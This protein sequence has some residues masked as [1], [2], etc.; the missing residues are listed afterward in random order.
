MALNLTVKALSDINQTTKTNQL[1][2]EIEGIDLI[3]GTTP[4][5]RFWQIGDNAVIGQDGLYI[6]GV[7]ENEKS[8][9]YISLDGTTR[10]IT[11]QI[12]EQGG[13]SSI[14]KMD[15][16]LVDKNGEVSNAL[17]KNQLLVDPIGVKANVY[18]AFTDTSG[19]GLSGQHPRDSI[20]IFNG[21][22]DGISFGVGNVVLSV[23]HP[24]SA[25]RQ[26][27]FVNQ[28]TE[29]ASA[30]TD[31]QTSIQL[32]STDNLL[33]PDGYMQSYI[34]VEDEIIQYQGK[35]LTTL[36][37]CTRGALGT[38]AVAHDIDTETSSIYRLTDNPINM[39]LGLM[40]SGSNYSN[41]TSVLHLTKI[42][43]VTSNVNAIVFDEYDIQERLGL[44]VGD[45]VLLE[46]TV[47][48]DFA[49]GK[50]TG[51]GKSS[52]GSYVL[53]TTDLTEELNTSATFST[54]SKYD[55][56][57]DGCAMKTDQVDIAQ[58]EFILS[59]FGTSFPQLQFYLKDTIKAKEFIEKEIYYPVSMGQVSRKGRASLRYNAPPVAGENVQTL[60]NDN[61]KNAENI[62]IKR[63]ANNNLFNSVIYKYNEDT[64]TDKFLSGLI[65][66]DATSINNIKVGNKPLT[67]ESKGL[68]KGSE[69]YLDSQ[70]VRYLDRFAG[71]AESVDVEVNFKTGFSI[72]VGDSVIFNPSISLPDTKNGTR[73]F[74][75]RIMECVNKSV[76]LL[77]GDIKLSLLDTS[78][79]INGRYTTIAPAS[80]IY[81]VNGSSVSVINLSTGQFDS[82]KWVDFEGQTVLVHS[83]DWTFQLE[84]TLTSVGTNLV[85]AN[86]TGV[87]SGMILDTPQYSGN[88]K[89]KA[90][91]KLRHGYINPHRLVTGQV[92]SNSFAVSNV[93]PFFIGA[94]LSLY[95]SD[96]STFRGEFTIIGISSNIMTVDRDVVVSPNDNINLLGFV[97][98]NGQPYRYL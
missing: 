37:G 19:R 52:Y 79:A 53:V 13:S 59:T 88:A 45:W 28:K 38:T 97:S 2:V 55:I 91:Y 26:D 70:S 92:A 29:L 35:V 36:T 82:S 21:V 6:G 27:L 54:K 5:Y 89:E 58:H 30:I 86:T 68:R 7:F 41:P 65:T 63:S 64:L 96:Y 32:K 66:I 69:N 90:F 20:K 17:S 83:S 31:V 85:L 24:E 57:R 84:T 10:N 1:I 23:S 98:D 50:I 42:D 56:Y 8:K 73:E 78:F 75:A 11:Q 44:S 46:G 33:N 22:I 40:L 4:V 77:T 87:T 51:F 61:I 43:A 62:K 48:N 39:A 25:K 76:N 94:T 74:D 72:E 14:A 71:A 9:P 60:T 49:D 16:V 95:S 67:I 15:I 80:Q 12:K 18:L 93:L 47:S 3:Y 34:Q 81:S